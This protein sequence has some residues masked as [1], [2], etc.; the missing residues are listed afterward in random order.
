MKTTIIA[1]VGECFNGSMDIAKKMISTA[2]SAGCDIVKFQLIDM[3]EVAPDDPEYE[4]FASL[5]LAPPKIDRILQWC[6]EEKISPLFTPVS[7][8]TANW[9]IDAGIDTVKI[10]SSFV[11]KK[12]LID[13]VNDN[14]DVVFA[15]TGMASLEEI[16]RL[17]GCLSKVREISLLHCISEYPTGPL[18]ELRG[19][20]AL[21][22]KDAHLNMMMILKE[23]YPDLYVGYSDHTDDIFV[24]VVAA[25]MGA[26]I[27]EKHFTLDRATPVKHYNEGLKY[28]GTDHVLSIEPEKL[29]KMVE[30][31][32]RVDLIKGDYCWERS[33]GERVLIDFL[34]GRY[35]ER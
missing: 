22:E 3:E 23:R 34:R 25:A 31:I 16:D 9:L 11:G 13:Y 4:W 29:K 28:L 35:R 1:E 5:D 14:F 33:S 7:V 27:I 8:K 32:R 12:E 30:L 15:S 17:I 10:A 24:P 21:D 6:C 26:D 20:R 18:L 2:K 19:L